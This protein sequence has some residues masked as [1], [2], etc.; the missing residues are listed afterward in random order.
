MF[1]FHSAINT[2]NIGDTF[3]AFLAAAK[4]LSSNAPNMSH[5]F[6]LP[7]ASMYVIYFG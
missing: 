6:V 4:A 2:P 5:S 7:G 3:E 1:F